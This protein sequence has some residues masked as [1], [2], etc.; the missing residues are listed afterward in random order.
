[1]HLGT[2]FY[3]ALGQQHLWMR[4]WQLSKG[5]CPTSKDHTLK[6]QKV[7]FIMQDLFLGVDGLSPVQWHPY[8]TVGGERPHTLVAHIKAYGRCALFLLLTSQKGLSILRRNSLE[9]ISVCCQIFRLQS[10][11]GCECGRAGHHHTDYPVQG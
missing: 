11:T 6:I 8:S 9:C 5:P 1:M 7:C 3:F 4:A 2:E 10:C